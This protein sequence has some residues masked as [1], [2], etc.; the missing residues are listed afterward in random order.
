[1]TFEEIRLADLAVIYNTDEFAKEA[2]YKGNKIAVFE[3]KDEIE[4][5]DVSFVRIKG[6]ESDFLEISEGDEI[7]IKGINYQIKNYSEPKDFQIT[8][9]IKEI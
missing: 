7:E 1:M 8:I 5:Y 2:V 9:S 3:V 6:M 4:I